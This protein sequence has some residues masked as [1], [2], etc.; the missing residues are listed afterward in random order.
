[1]GTSRSAHISP[2]KPSMPAGSPELASCTNL[3]VSCTRL[4]P[5]TGSRRGDR[6]E[7]SNK[8][9]LGSMHK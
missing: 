2:N 7:V 8:Q 1:M 9:P 5:D 3:Q 6:E 4:C